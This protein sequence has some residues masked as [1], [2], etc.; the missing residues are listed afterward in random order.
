VDVVFP[1]L[2]GVVFPLISLAVIV[3]VVI[4]IVRVVQAIQS[5]AAAMD[6][7]AAALE[8]KPPT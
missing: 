3:V 8:K 4:V 2:L 6:R 1:T 7:I 5:M